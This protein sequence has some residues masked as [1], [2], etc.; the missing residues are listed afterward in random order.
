MAIGNFTVDE[1]RETITNETN[2]KSIYD[3]IKACNDV[4]GDDNNQCPAICPML[5]TCST[6]LNRWADFTDDSDK[7]IYEVQKTYVD[8]YNDTEVKSPRSRTVQT[9]KMG[10]PDA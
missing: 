4:N 10:E 5:D 9:R 2:A 8:S 6:W 7:L 1:A 3:A